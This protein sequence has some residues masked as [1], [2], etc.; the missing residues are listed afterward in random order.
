VYCAMIELVLLF[1]GNKLID[2]M[3]DWFQWWLSLR[4]HVV[5]VTVM[6]CLV[7]DRE[8][9][10]Q[11]HSD[12]SLPFFEC[13]LNTSLEVCEK[14]DVKGLYKKAREGKIKGTTAAPYFSVALIKTPNWQDRIKICGWFCSVLSAPGCVPMNARTP[15]ERT[16]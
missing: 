15:A 5:D 6:W 4:K 13:F 10:R 11:L 12:C 8:N 16:N 9:A 7:Q 2:R 1:V 3:I 14:R